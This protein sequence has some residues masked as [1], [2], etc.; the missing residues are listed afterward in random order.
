MI[1][2]NEMPLD[3][4][5][6]EKILP[7]LPKF[8]SQEGKSEPEMSE[9]ESAFLCGA[10]KT[11]HPKKILEVGVAGGATTAIILQALEELGESYEM[12]SVDMLEKFYRDS[13]KT[14]GFMA[15]F[16]KK[17]NLLITPPQSTLC[18]THEFYL[19]KYLPQVI[20]EIG[21]DIDFVIL[22]TVHAMPGEGLD[23]LAVL[24]YLKDGAIVVLHDVSYNQ[25]KTQ[26]INGHATAVLFSTVTAEKFLNFD[27][28]FFRYPNIAAFRVSEQTA[29]NI[30][31]VFLSMILRWA[32]LP[33]EEEIVTYRRHY[34]RFYPVEMCEIFQEAIDMNAYNFWIA[35][36]K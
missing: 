12:H 15:T 28:A 25:L 32:Y 31:N 10:I 16:A 5:P 34:Q 17:N 33:S 7:K 11:Y 13:S 18:G 22:D 29:E 9:S 21:G 3:F 4:E 14:S 6:R 36:R 2:I 19:G 27:E 20:D 24:P 26:G 23:F 35:Q 30:D 1:H 8:V